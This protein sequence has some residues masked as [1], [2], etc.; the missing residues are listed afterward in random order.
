MQGQA[1]SLDGEA[2]VEAYAPLHGRNTIG[3]GVMTAE[4]HRGNDYETLVTAHMIDRCLE[5]GLPV[6]WSCETENPAS[7]SIARKL[8]FQGERTCPMRVYRSAKPAHL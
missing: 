5:Q 2:L 1:P 4:A 3:L 8:G 7:A 6:A